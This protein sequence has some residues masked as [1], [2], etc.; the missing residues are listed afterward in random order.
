M[1]LTKLKSGVNSI[2]RVT[3]QELLWSKRT[4]TG[5]TGVKLLFH[6]LPLITFAADSDLHDV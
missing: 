3:P 5:V 1:M 4:R 6:Y 2:A